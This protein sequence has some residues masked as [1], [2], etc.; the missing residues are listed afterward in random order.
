MNRYR[1]LFVIVAVLA[2]ALVM[3]TGCT[4]SQDE[5]TVTVEL[6]ENPSTGYTWSYSAEPEG[7]LQETSSE[8]IGSDGQDEE[9]VGAPGT[10]VY[11]FKVVSDGTVTLRFESKRDWDGGYADRTYVVSYQVK[12]GV[13]EMLTDEMIL[14]SEDEQNNQS[15]SAY[16]RVDQVTEDNGDI[17]IEGVYMIEDE[18]AQGMFVEQDGTIQ[19]LALASD[20]S[21]DF[22][23]TLGPET[24]K[25]TAQEFVQKFQEMD[26]SEAAVYRVTLENGVI[27]SLSYV[28]LP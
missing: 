26:Y 18:S 11:T 20:A 23:E 3:M 25:I 17:L 13:P 9:I 2:A 22:S 28:Y 15:D 6:E 4:S 5:K 21:V 10:R 8:F 12:N 7:I 19:K 14:S 27:T 24:T 16:L 1:K